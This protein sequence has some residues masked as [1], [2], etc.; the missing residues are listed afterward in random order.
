MELSRDGELPC[1][2]MVL[3]HTQSHL[4]EGTL[5]VNKAEER[6]WLLFRTMNSTQE[7]PLLHNF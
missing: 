7:V 5:E 3:T 1:S 6:S 4:P 2:T